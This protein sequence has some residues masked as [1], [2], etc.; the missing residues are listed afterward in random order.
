MR[1]SVGGGG[2]IAAMRLTA[3]GEPGLRMTGEVVPAGR[4][5][6]W[7]TAAVAVGDAR[8]GGVTVPVPIFTVTVGDLVGTGDAAS[9]EPVRNATTHN[10]AATLRQRRRDVERRP[11]D[12][13][14]V[15][16]SAIVNQSRVERV[17]DREGAPLNRCYNSD[18]EAGLP[19][20]PH[21]SAR[22]FRWRLKYA[23]RQSCAR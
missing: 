18:T 10:A 1:G 17:R 2:T 12:R 20:R 3:V 8:A 11:T 5:V 9:T 6:V 13:S 19:L 15:T 4:T 7:A 16:H 21:H 14:R 22:G 23:C